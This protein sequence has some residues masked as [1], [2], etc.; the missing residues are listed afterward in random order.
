MSFVARFGKRA[1]LTVLLPALGL[2]ATAPAAQAAGP[3]DM[4]FF[5]TSV[6]SGKGANLGGLEGAD[7]HCAALA[8]G[9]GNTK[10]N[11]RAYLSTTAPGGDAG[12]NARDRVKG[13]I[14]AKDVDN[15]HSPSIRRTPISTR[16]PR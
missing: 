16:R 2:L 13:I 10:K 12:V 14:I 6:G 15:L 1:V 11:W 8:A 4:T 3:E 5:L 7:A 9:V